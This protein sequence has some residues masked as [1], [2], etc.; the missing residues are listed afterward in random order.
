MHID[1]DRDYGVVEWL[2]VSRVNARWARE[3]SGMIL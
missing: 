2:I 1:N 3:L